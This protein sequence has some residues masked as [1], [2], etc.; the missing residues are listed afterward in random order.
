M[1]F[2]SDSRV[3]EILQLFI[4]Y[5]L[6]FLEVLSY[7]DDRKLYLSHLLGSANPRGHGTRC[8][9]TTVHVTRVLWT[10]SPV[11]TR[12]PRCTA[13]ADMAFQIQ[14]LL[15]SLKA[16]LGGGGRPG[17]SAEAEN[18]IKSHTP[19]ATFS[20]GPASKQDLGPRCPK[21]CK[22]FGESPLSLRKD[23]LPVAFSNHFVSST[24]PFLSST[25]PGTSTFSHRLQFFKTQ[26]LES[27]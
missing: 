1:N 21:T 11:H 23:S 20:W 3:Q 12:C 26:K 8:R 2:S 15:P 19:A 9:G 5:K 27:L 18:P 14:Q 6:I 17:P 16:L 4:F 10:E 22:K 13:P 24:I 7:Q 25:S